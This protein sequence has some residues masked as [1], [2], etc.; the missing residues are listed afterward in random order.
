MRSMASSHPKG[1][2][3]VDILPAWA[4]WIIAAVTLLFS[5][6]F[7]F[8]MALAVEIL[9]GVL[10]EAG[11]P[12]LLVLAAAVGIGRFLLRKFW[13]SPPTSEFVKDQA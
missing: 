8:L 10:K 2:R 7:A 5:P 9:V 13:A 6:V 11:L 12:G 4:W 3:A 1:H